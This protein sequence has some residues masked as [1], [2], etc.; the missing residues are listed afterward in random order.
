LPL[1]HLVLATLLLVGV[2][3]ARRPGPHPG[4]R[5]GMPAGCSGTTAPVLFGLLARPLTLA[6]MVGQLERGCLV[7]DEVR[8]RAG[9]TAIQISSPAGFAQVARALGLAQGAYRVMVPAETAPG[10]PPDTVQA[11]RRGIVLREELARH[12]ASLRRLLEG[13]GMPHPPLTASRGAARPMLVRV[14]DH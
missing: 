5:R 9:N 3:P 4:T 10:W 12:G 14:F 13:T 1:R 6:E 7:L 2:W 11:L 8:F